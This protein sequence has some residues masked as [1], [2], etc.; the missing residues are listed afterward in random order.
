MGPACFCGPP[1]IGS[2]S[3]VGT[4]GRSAPE[5]RGVAPSDMPPAI[6]R[7]PVAGMVI[8]V[9]IIVGGGG[10]RLAAESEASSGRDV[11]LA[12]GRGGD[13][14]GST[15][16]FLPLVSEPQAEPALTSR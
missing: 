3:G 7:A 13:D 12:F 10:I 11:V 1:L 16:S 5:M 8:G 6:G 4:I 15:Y 9:D 2:A 14:G